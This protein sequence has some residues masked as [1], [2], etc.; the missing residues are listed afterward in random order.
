MEFTD[1]ELRPVV[2]KDVALT[3]VFLLVNVLAP[4]FCLEKRN[5]F[6]WKQ[7]ISVFLQFL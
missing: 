3:I 6:C 5:D 2:F 4:Q 1:N 7:V